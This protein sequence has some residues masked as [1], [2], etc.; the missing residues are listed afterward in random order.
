MITIYRDAQNTLIYDSRPDGRP[1][2]S[3]PDARTRVTSA[4]WFCVN[5]GTVRSLRVDGRCEVC[6]SD[7]VVPA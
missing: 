1:F 5:C 4:T 3:Q 6:I 7:A 2:T